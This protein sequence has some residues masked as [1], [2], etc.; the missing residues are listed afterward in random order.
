MSVISYKVKAKGK[1]NWREF[2]TVRLEISVGQQYHEGGK[3]KAATDWARK[4]FK[5]KVLIL[6]DTT[7]RFNMMFTERISEQE[8][9]EITLKAGDDWLMRNKEFLDGIEITR[10]N[11]W[12][13][14]PEYEIIYKQVMS[15]YKNDRHF[16]TALQNAISEVWIR[17]YAETNN[18]ERFFAISEKYLLEETAVL[19]VAYEN[20]GGISAYPGD[21]LELWEMFIEAT[22]NE[23]PKGLK[24]AHCTRLCFQRKKKKE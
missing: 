12:M 9:Y 10:W 17:R 19:A 4:N 16:Y 1:W 8:A 5:N 7:Q 21:F 3:L 13:S 14:H 23:V 24:N 15:L 18:E 6:G 20:I 2:D 22:S 11:D